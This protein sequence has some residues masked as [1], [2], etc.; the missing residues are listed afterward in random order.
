MCIRTTVLSSPVS[1]L[2]SKELFR[3]CPYSGPSTNQVK[4]LCSFAVGIKK[5][6]CAICDL[7]NDKKKEAGQNPASRHF[8][9]CFKYNSWFNFYFGDFRYLLQL[10]PCP[11]HFTLEY[12]SQHVERKLLNVFRFLS[13]PSKSSFL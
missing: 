10:Q 4:K 12:W 7:K 2:P 13:V 5:P 8:L 9:S 1:A 3:A 6:F 11:F